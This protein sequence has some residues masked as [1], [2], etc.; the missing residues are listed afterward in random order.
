M[1]KKSVYFLRSLFVTSAFGFALSLIIAL[2]SGLVLAAPPFSGTVWVDPNI[3]TEDDPT[4][5]IEANYAGTG[6]REMFDRRVN[7]WVMQD[8]YL[9][10]AIYNDDLTIEIQVNT[11]FGTIEAAQTEANFYGSAIGRIPYVLRTDVQTSWIH[12]GDENFGGGNNNILIHTDYGSKVSQTGFLE[13]ILV[14]E[15]VHTSL[16][17]THA[18]SS[19]WIQAQEADQAFI[20]TYARDFPVRED[21]AESFLPYLALNFRGDRLT[22]NVKN[23]I[24]STMPNRIAYFENQGFRM[25]PVSQEPKEAF[26]EGL[27]AFSGSWYDPSR[28]GEGF[29]FEFGRNQDTPVVTVYWFTHSDGQ[30]YWLIGASA[31]DIDLFEASGEI[32]F[33]LLEV[34]GT[35]FGDDFAPG[36]LQRIQRGKLTIWIESCEKLVAMWV[37]T[38]GSS[39]PGPS[40]IEYELKRITAGLDGLSCSSDLDAFQ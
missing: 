4:T 28:D 13:E 21:L 20:S 27:G 32:E 36:E 1:L 34:S 37:P 16:D 24:R 10:D 18:Q 12:K 39:V 3:I 11:E 33:D 19:G 38:Q 8:A 15:G 31:Y 29:V 5:F 9:F 40:P 2:D 35:G 6:I 25:D 30:P 26:V 17:A 7:G 14:H 22:D 23:T